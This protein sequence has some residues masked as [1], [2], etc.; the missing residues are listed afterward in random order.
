MGVGQNK[1]GVGGW[2]EE[3]GERRKGRQ[4]VRCQNIPLKPDVANRQ[5]VHLIHRSLARTA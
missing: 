2:G 1:G 4:G 3:G 5:P